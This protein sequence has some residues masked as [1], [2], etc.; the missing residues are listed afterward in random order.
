MI[1]RCILICRFQIKKLQSLKYNPNTNLFNTP[2]T[3]LFYCPIYQVYKNNTKVRQKNKV[4]RNLR[5][6]GPRGPTMSGP[7]MFGFI[8][9]WPTILGPGP[10]LIGTGG[11][12]E[13]EQQ[14]NLLNMSILHRHLLVPY[15]CIST[16]ILF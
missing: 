12:T 5:I 9:F 13:V 2:P 8:G 14:N 10:T 7:G 1:Y 15:T 16:C 3:T 4:L 11:P 6:I